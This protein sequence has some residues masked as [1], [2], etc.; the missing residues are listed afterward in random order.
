MLATSTAA[1]AHAHARAA[2]SASVAPCV[3][4]AFLGE[5]NKDH[6]TPL[7]LA[8]SLRPQRGRRLRTNAYAAYSGYPDEGAVDSDEEGDRPLLSLAHAED[9]QMQ[10]EVIRT[11]VA[12]GADVYARKALSFAP[13]PA[14][15]SSAQQQQQQQ[16]RPPLGVGVG[17]KGRGQR[18]RVRA[19]LGRRACARAA[20]GTDPHGGRRGEP[21]RAP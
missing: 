11:L 14:P 15:V 19:D 5:L 9:E 4:P 1:G 3:R 16:Q 20:N 13:A 21:R 12:L 10:L 8:V 17:C 6:L 7:Q 18:C 2:A